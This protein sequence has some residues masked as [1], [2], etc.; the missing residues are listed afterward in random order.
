MASGSLLWRGLFLRS[1]KPT[2]RGAKLITQGLPHCL[3]HSRL[4]FFAEAFF[5]KA[6]KFFSK[7]LEQNPRP[8]AQRL[9]R[10]LLGAGGCA[11][12]G[13]LRPAGRAFMRAAAQ[14]QGSTLEKRQDPRG[15]LPFFSPAAF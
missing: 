6:G 8:A 15:A 2:V 4:K 3:R 11:W 9:S 1:A 13:V 7:G 12:T 5:K 14:V 10:I